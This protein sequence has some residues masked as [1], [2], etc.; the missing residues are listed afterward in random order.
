MP[1]KQDAL[2]AAGLQRAFP[3]LVEDWVFPVRRL[4]GVGSSL[5]TKEEAPQKGA[6]GEL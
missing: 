5:G 6:S 3:A 2:L 1:W 4:P